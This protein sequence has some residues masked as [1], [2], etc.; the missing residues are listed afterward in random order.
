MCESIYKKYPEKANSDRKQ[1][2]GSHGLGEGGQEVT[3]KWVWGN[4]NVLELDN[5]NGGIIL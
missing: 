2:S 1:I 3:A 5:D 4:E